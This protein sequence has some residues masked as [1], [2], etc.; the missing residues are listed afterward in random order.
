MREL[1]R[2]ST[3]APS[4]RSNPEAFVRAMT[5]S[6]LLG[7]LIPKE[8]GGMGLGHSERPAPAASFRRHRVRCRRGHDPADHERGTLRRPLRHQRAQDLH[9]PRTTLG[10]HGPVRSHHAPRR[11][12]EALPWP[13]G[14]SR[15][16]R[17]AVGNG[18]TV[19]QRRVMMNNET[20][21]LR[22]ENLRV[23]AHSLEGEGFR[24]IMDGMNA[25]RRLGPRN[26]V[27]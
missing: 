17:E 3:G 26:A 24:Y 23:P 4:T 8:Y 18:L 7:A 16:L 9:L 20:N 2:G 27:G 1:P 12:R 5:E 6:G 25:E 10:P 21:E 22:F 15:R 14:L 13:L 11:G 19:K